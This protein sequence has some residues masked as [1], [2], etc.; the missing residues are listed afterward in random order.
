M[1]DHGRFDPVERVGEH[2]HAIEEPARCGDQRQARP[3]D[4]NRPVAAPGRHH[5]Q[6]RED[7]R[8][9][10]QLGEFDADVERQQRHD[11]GPAGQAQVTQDAGERHAVHQPEGQ[12][13]HRFA[14][15]HERSQG[16]DRR[17][18]DRGG[19]RHLDGPTGHRDPAER[20]GDERQRVA[21]GERGD[22]VQHLDRGRSGPG[23]GNPPV[24]DGEQGRRQEQREEEQEVVGAVEDVVQAESGHVDHPDSE[25]AVADRDRSFR[26]REHPGRR[27]PVLCVHDDQHRL[28]VGDGL[29]DRVVGDRDVGRVGPADVDGEVHLH[30][31]DALAALAE[32][33]GE[34]HRPR[35]PVGAADR[36]VFGQ[37][38]L[39]LCLVRIGAQH[40][41]PLRR[42]QRL[43]E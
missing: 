32:V 16:V 20:R 3:D 24:A 36:Q 13:D 11:R 9:D 5:L 28:V 4:A 43:V 22:D 19:D 7:R 26:R 39:D 14:A 8:G 1:R 17:H 33:A 34:V 37:V 21:E 30:R 41:G 42:R 29:D 35:V 6:R 27:C 25:G 38:G 40:I 2:T 10:Q 31:L 23:A 12:R 18:A 15:T